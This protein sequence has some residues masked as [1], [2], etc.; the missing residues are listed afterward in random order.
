ML[1]TRGDGERRERGL[2]SYFSYCEQVKYID[3]GAFLCGSRCALGVFFFL[4]IFFFLIF[5]CGNILQVV[6][7]WLVKKKKK[8][9]IDSEVR[10]MDVRAI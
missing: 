10:M 9:N 6:A 2:E 8:E 3:F 1:R 5:F 7:V 4:S